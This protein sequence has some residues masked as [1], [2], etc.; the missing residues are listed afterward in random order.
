MIESSDRVKPWRLDVKHTAL[1]LL[2]RNWHAIVDK[3][4]AVTATFVFARPKSH[5]RANGNLKGNAPQH[6]VT[7]IGDLDKLCRAVFDALTGIA[8]DD[9]SQVFSLQAERRYAVDNEPQG[10]H[11]TIT[12]IDV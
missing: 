9:D 11:I 5:F 12:T 10:V 4:M 7:R 3:P 8:Y 6:C 2:P 1:S